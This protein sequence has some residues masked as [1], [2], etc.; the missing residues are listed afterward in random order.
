M[1]E[2]GTW[3][4]QPEANCCSCFALEE[5]NVNQLEEENKRRELKVDM[6]VLPVDRRFAFL[7]MK[8]RRGSASAP[9]RE[10]EVSAA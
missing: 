8:Q 5:A 2:G 6:G 4:L 10:I 9:A 3:N 1:L 7:R